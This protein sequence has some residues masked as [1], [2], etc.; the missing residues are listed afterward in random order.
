MA[1]DEPIAKPGS[2]GRGRA[3]F[4]IPATWVSPWLQPSNQLQQGLVFLIPSHVTFVRPASLDDMHDVFPHHVV[5]IRSIHIH[6]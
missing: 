5:I 1:D 3:V 4:L 6:N 2:E